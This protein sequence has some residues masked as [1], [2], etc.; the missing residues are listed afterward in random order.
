MEKQAAEN[1]PP[2]WRTRGVK[3]S[4]KLQTCKSNMYNIDRQQGCSL[5]NIIL[6]NPAL[7]CAQAVYW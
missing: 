7:S 1:S 5:L 3:P 2:T 4:Y 6:W